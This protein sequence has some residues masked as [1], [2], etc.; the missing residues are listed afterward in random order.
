VREIVFT[1][2]GNNLRLTPSGEN[3]FQDAVKNQANNRGY[4]KREVKGK[5]SHQI[6]G[7]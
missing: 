6:G 2:R 4:D 3:L 5:T 7:K 1:E